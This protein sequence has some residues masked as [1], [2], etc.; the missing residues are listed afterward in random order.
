MKFLNQIK[1]FD[2]DFQ[3]V[4]RRETLWIFVCLSGDTVAKELHQ[5]FRL[6]ILL[7][8]VANHA[9]KTIFIELVHLNLQKN[10]LLDVKR[11]LLPLVGRKNL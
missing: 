1:Q 9:G 4:S 5:N 2:S 11:F 7:F 8:L 3:T 10:L 6:A